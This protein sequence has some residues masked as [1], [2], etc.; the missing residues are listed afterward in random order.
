MSGV[1]M[2]SD[3]DTLWRAAVTSGSL[4]G[5][6][7]FLRDGKEVGW[8]PAISLERT[9]CLD[10]MLLLDPLERLAARL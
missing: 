3:N 10:A 1:P 5:Y 8:K 2:P 4:E 9:C 6:Q 7:Q